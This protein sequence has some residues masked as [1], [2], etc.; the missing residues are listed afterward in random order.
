MC[1]CVCVCVCMC[2]CSKIMIAVHRALYLNI[3]ILHICY[4]LFFLIL[5]TDL[6]YIILYIYI[7]IYIYIYKRE[8]SEHK[9]KGYLSFNLYLMFKLV[10]ENI[11][12]LNCFSTCY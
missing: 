11:R 10:K 1:V 7:Y 6:I 2:V 12:N 3:L 4:G 5:F 8:Y 9:G